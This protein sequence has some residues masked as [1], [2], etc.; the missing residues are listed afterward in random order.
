VTLQTLARRDDATEVFAGYGLVV[1]DECHH[2]PAVTF[3]RCVRAAANRRWVG[4][5]ATPRRRD[6]LE[7][8]LHMQLGPVRHLM[9]EDAASMVL[10][11]RDLVVHETLTDPDVPE[12]AP[13]QTVLGRVAA[14]EERTRNIC[15]DVADAHRRHRNVLVFTD[16]TEHLEGLRDELSARHGLQAAVLKGETGKKLHKSILEQ[17]RHSDEPILLLAT[18]AYLGEGFD[19]P[20]L[21]TLF[22]TFPISGRSR[23]VQYVGRVTRALP[24]KTSVEVHDYHDSLHP[25]LRRMHQRRL[26][27]LKSIGFVPTT[28]V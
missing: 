13:V 1:V 27:A 16:R 11:R 15:M 12:G 28:P 20:E 7:G 17:L 9:S 26:V 3:E 8:I 4:L 10:V 18:G 21:D 24:G 6:G 25:L 5:T 14:D 22:L 23:F 19:L 2:L